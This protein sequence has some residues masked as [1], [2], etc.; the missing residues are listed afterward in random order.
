MGYV[1]DFAPGK[2]FIGIKVNGKLNFEVAERYSIE[3]LK[4][5]RQNG[6][7]KFLIDHKETELDAAG[8]YKLHTDGAALE[9]FGF[10]SSDKI[11][12]VISRA[13]DDHPFF[14]KIEHNAKWSNFKYFDTVAKA[15]TWLN[16][17]S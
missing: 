15:L 10:K 12:I 16:N 5:A 1:I 9:K 3:A 8:I 13:K 2:D 11:A 14:E 4:M 17:D 7:H 6:Y